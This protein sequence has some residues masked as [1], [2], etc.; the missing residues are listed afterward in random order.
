MCIQGFSLPQKKKISL[1]AHQQG[2]NL[3]NYSIAIKYKVIHSI[4]IGKNGKLNLH[5]TEYLKEH[6]LTL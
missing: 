3:L 6:I 4:K 5:H 1:N 2:N